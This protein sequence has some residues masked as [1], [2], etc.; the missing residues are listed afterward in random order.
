MPN[1]YTSV[2]AIIPGNLTVQGGLNV[3][4]N[5]VDLA[6]GTPFIQIGSP[7]VG[8]PRQV[9]IGYSGVAGESLTFNLNP[10][11]VTR[12]STGIPA[13][14]LVHDPTGAKFFL[15]IVN[16]A[17][18]PMDTAPRLAVLTDFTNHI[19][20][21][22]TTENTIY[23]KVIRAGLLGSNGA[24]AFAVQYN[25]TAAGAGTTNVRVR[26][27]GTATILWS[28]TGVG[29]RRC[30]G[31]VFAPNNNALANHEEVTFTDAAVPSMGNGSVAV[32]WTI[33]QTMT[34]TAQSANAGDS[35]TFSVCDVSLLNTF[36]PV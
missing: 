6:A 10:D 9:R 7:S 5:L 14:A 17:G 13:Y 32:D 16:A 12:D 18:N 1:S 21:G 24:L 23:S 31:W 30:E 28:F 27:G 36:G 3:A 33:D 34:I 11:L 22:N 20:T 35:Q 19:N 4:G 2:P 29:K 8:S 15:R 25:A 26:F